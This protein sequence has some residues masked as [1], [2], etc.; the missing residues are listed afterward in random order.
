MKLIIKS[1]SFRN[2]SGAII[3]AQV[4]YYGSLLLGA[5]VAPIK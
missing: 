1:A 4:D 5:A 3:K 2:V